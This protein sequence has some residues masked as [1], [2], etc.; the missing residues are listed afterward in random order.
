[1]P[2]SKRLSGV[3]C[4]VI[5]PFNQDLSPNPEKLI[6]QCRWLLS[7]KVGLTV[8]GTTSEANSM[9]V[10]EK[11]ALLDTIADAGIDRGR[12]IAGTGC[13]AL[14]DTVQLTA[15]AAELGLAGALMLPPFYY[16]EVSD[17][18]LFASYAEV[19]ERVANT[20][21][22]IYLYHIP[23]VA[24]V[25]LSLDLVERL[26]KTYPNTIAG[27]KDSSGDWGNTQAMLARGWDDFRV[28]AGSE[29]LL[30]RTLRGGGAGCI[31]A[32]A[33]INPAAMQQL[34][35]GWQ[36][37]HALSRQEKLGTIRAIVQRYPVIPALKTIVAHYAE[38]PGWDRLRPP[39][40][41]LQPAQKQSLMVALRKHGF[42]M[43]SL[44]TG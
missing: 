38:D 23:P 32:T 7:Q 13:A 12:V 31:S 24:Q 41:S 11:I 2:A 22:R 14:S 16:K 17:D 21:L 20:D 36:T 29:T 27:I 42:D 19:I 37:E 33:N 1:M 30:L 25:G 6:G 5:T 39:L 9:S 26:V 35:A 43:P 18:G 28:F 15:Q 34:F 40:I 8:F 4:P 3:L 10:A 44:A